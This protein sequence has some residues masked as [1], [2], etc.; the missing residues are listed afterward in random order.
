LFIHLPGR[1]RSGR[2]YIDICREMEGEIAKKRVGG[3]RIKRHGNRDLS[4][5]YET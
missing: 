3:W 2:N 5:S 1:K 4:G